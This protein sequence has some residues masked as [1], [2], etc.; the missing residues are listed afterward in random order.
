[1]ADVDRER[2]PVGVNGGLFDLEAVIVVVCMAE[3]IPVG[4]GQGTGEL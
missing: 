3:G 1:M 4:N 2:V